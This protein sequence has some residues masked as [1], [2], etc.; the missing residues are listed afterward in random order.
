MEQGRKEHL[1][2]EG[3]LDWSNL[4]RKLP[5]K[6]HYCRKDTRDKKC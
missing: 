4:Y 5:S 3:S 2:N 6:I 1:L